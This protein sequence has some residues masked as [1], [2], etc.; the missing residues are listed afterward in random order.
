MDCTLG[1]GMLWYL[2]LTAQPAAFNTHCGKKFVTPRNTDIHPVMPNPA[3]TAAIFPNSS[4]HTSTKFVYLTRT[5]QSI[6]P[7]RNSSASWSQKNSTSP[8]QVVSL[9]SRRSQ[10]SKFLLT[11]SLSTLNLKKKT[12]KTSI[13]RLKSLFKAKP[14]LKSLSRK[15]TGIKKQ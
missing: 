11:S 2:V 12:C 3:L 7:A 4:E 9:A 14:Y 15:L 5:T 6:V 1:C 8:F 13:R 10:V